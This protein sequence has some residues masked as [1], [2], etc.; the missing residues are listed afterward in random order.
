MTPEQDVLK[1]ARF[2]KVE[3]G[4]DVQLAVVDNLEAA[5]EASRALHE[6]IV[7]PPSVDSQDGDTGRQHVLADAVE[8]QRRVEVAVSAVQTQHRIDCQSAWFR[9]T[10]R[11]FEAHAV[12]GSARDQFYLHEV[13]S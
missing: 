1:A 6:H 3:P 12:A 5:T 9:V 13:H 4:G 2:E 10:Q 11:A 7:M 8:E